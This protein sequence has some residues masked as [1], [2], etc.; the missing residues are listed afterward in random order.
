MPPG[1]SYSPVF[2]LKPCN[3]NI[4]MGFHDGPWAKGLETDGLLEKPALLPLLLERPCS[5]LTPGLARLLAPA[6]PHTPPPLAIFPLGAASSQGL[7]WISIEKSPPLRSL[8][9]YPLS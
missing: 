5:P 9:Y 3:E 4:F 6:I 1:N 8:P 7:S 2:Y